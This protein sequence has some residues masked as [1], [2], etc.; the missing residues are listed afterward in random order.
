MQ[1]GNHNPS[2]VRL[3]DPSAELSLRAGILNG[4]TMLPY[5]HSGTKFEQML[6]EMLHK[7]VRKEEEMDRG[8]G[9][10]AAMEGSKT[11][12][13]GVG[14]DR[15]VSPDRRREAARSGEGERGVL[16]VTCRWCSQSF[17][18]VAVLLQHERYLCKMNKE[19]VEVIEDLRGKD[20]HSPPL[21]FPRPALQPENSEPSDVSNGL[22]PM[23]KPSWHSLP[24]Q[25]LVAM[26]SPPQPHHDA[27]SSSRAYCS[28]QDKRSPS[29]P[30]HHSPKLS[31]PRVRKRVPSSGFG[32]PVRL[33][34]CAPEL[35][36]PQNQTSSPWSAQS[37]PLDL[38]LPKQLLDRE[39]RN[40]T[41]NGFS[42]RGEGRKEHRTQLLRRPSPTSHLPLQPH[43]IFGGAAAPM[44]PGSL[45][46]GYHV[47]NQSGL[48]LSGHD[49]ITA[50]PFSQQVNS[51]GFLSP[52]A[53]M[54]D[55]DAEA[56]LKKIHLERQ[57]LMV[58][59]VP[60]QVC[61][62]QLRVFAEE[63]RCRGSKKNRLKYLILKRCCKNLR[64]SLTQI[65]IF[66]LSH[67]GEV[68]SHG[69][70]DYL[71]LVDEGLEGEGGPSKKRLR[72]TDEGLYA[73]DICEKTFQKS[74]SLLRHKYEHTGK[75][76]T[77]KSSMPFDMNHTSRQFLF[78][79]LN[80]LI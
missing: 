17:P 21:F 70:L 19:T 30:I 75:K 36:S 56:T 59:S 27:S 79:C 53:Y 67:Q 60:L 46:N 77:H 69:A 37:E 55:A 65:G 33:A 9:G 41:L 5:L 7:E 28:S 39:G 32:S 80:I 74:S 22:S 63:Q 18:N 13:N 45:Y 43:P 1:D 73:C 52:L 40:K 15:M 50:I 23:Q 11:V 48:G 34:S 16:G 25:L 20:H 4:T 49:G 54:M 44:F 29:Q 62:N 72:K 26:Y 64:N 8:E 14:A 51:P 2:L 6:Q 76:K 66:M 58:S 10:G 42:A 31:S 68:L 35:T 71:S 57:A 78:K 12:Y 3:W 61:L 24:Q 47:F 38:S